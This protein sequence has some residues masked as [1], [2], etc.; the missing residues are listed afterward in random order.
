MK[1][2]KNTEPAPLTS[3]D[4]DTTSITIS[5]DEG[6]MTMI[7]DVLTSTLYTDKIS[8]QLRE[9]GCNGYDANVEAGNQDKPLK[10]RLPNKLDQSLS[11]RDFG[12]GMNKEQIRKVF[13]QLGRSTK[14]NSN[15]FT[16]MLGIG[17]KAGFAYGD[18]FMVTSF[19]KGRKVVYNA[20]RDKGKPQLAQMHEEDTTEPD[21]LEIKIPVRQT[22]MA[23][24]ARKAERVFRYFKVLPELTG[25][26]ITWAD[27]KHEF[28]G[29]GWR[30]TGNGASVAIM[31]NVGYNLD[32]AAMGLPMDQVDNFIYY[33]TAD[34]QDPLRLAILIKMGIELDFNIGELE[35]A[36]NREGLQYKDLTKKAITDRLQK[37][38]SELSGVFSKKMDSAKNLWEAKVAYATLFEHG[39]YGLSSLE[40]L[41]AKDILWKGKKINGSTF[42]LRNV[43]Q[44]AGIIVNKYQLATTMRHPSLSML[45]PT[46]NYYSHNSN[47]DAKARSDTLLVINDLPSGKQS[48]TR[49]KGWF[50]QNAKCEEIIV[51]TFPDDTAKKTYLKGRGLEEGQLVKYS[52]L[53]QYVAPPSNTTPSVHR[54]KHSAQVF[55]LDETY[56]GN[57]GS[58]RSGFWKI[59]SVDLKTEGGSYVKLDAFYIKTPLLQTTNSFTIESSY[60]FQR[61]VKAMRK[62]GL[63]TGPVYGLKVA[64]FDPA[65][66][67]K[68]GPKW[69]ALETEI[70]NN[71]AK[72]VKKATI[73]QELADSNAAISYTR[74][75]AEKHASKFPKSL[76]RDYLLSIDKM[77]SASALPPELRSLI[78][79]KSCEAWVK[80]PKTLPP[81]SI[82]LASEEKK[83]YAKY[84]MLKHINTYDLTRDEVIKTIADYVSLIESV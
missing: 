52:T 59:E 63:I 54:N 4:M 35:I 73:A 80:I 18:Q 60:D 74:K 38:M 32:G 28:G 56:A 6:D 15:E 51:F 78:N 81:P 62:A 31:G 46:Y 71:W 2:A 50:E 47:N 33:P 3:G 30:Y 13:C 23:E 40:R 57:Y 61:N 41:I 58:V 42:D 55:V 25:A 1:S 19:V 75:I 10:V 53:P 84:P 77:N 69:V 67:S 72:M 76:M 29:T 14:R 83:V 17:S 20:Y 9:Y 70:D 82:N 27:R 44:T 26:T 7:M 21:G 24:F 65:L 8:A 68:L 37:I 12:F 79:N 5:Q 43:E 66:P 48:P 22:D 45:I 64:M 36:A 11:I 16:G 34:L 49:L 39:T